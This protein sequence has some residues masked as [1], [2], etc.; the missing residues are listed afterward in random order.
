MSSPEFD[1]DYTLS[2]R[3]NCDTLYEPIYYYN[4]INLLLLKEIK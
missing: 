4:Y 1:D 3:Y 2:G